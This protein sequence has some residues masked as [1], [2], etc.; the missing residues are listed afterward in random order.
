MMIVYYKDDF[1]RGYLDNEK[2]NICETP[3]ATQDKIPRITSNKKKKI[4]KRL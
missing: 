1:M 4:R 3:L 2:K